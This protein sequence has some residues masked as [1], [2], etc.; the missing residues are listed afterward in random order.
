MKTISTN[1]QELQAEKAPCPNTREEL[2]EYIDSLLALPADY[3]MAVYVASLSATATLNYI[4]KTKGMTGF[5][6]G[7]VDLDIMRRVCRLD[8]PF[9]IIKAEDMLYP[10]YDLYQKLTEAMRIWMP[11]ASNRAATLL[12]EDLTYVAPAV[13]ARWKELAA[14]K[15]SFPENQTQTKE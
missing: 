7:C 2:N 5:Q 11:W 9:M 13:V 1:E 6:M 10:Q 14:S 15:N 8:C 12:T 3:G 4:G